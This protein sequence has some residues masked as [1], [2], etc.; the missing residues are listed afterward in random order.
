MDYPP[1]AFDA[2]IDELTSQGG[3]LLPEK[4]APQDIHYKG[5]GYEE[6]IQEKVTCGCGNSTR[7]VMIYK[8]DPKIKNPQSGTG[9]VTVCAV[10][11][12]VGAMPNF[13]DAV[14]DVSPEL[15]PMFYD[16]EDDDA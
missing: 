16:Q 14:Y 13:C 8:P 7:M 4:C 2:L 10:C 12:S 11:D 6:S 1:Q 3:A 5:P 9:Y 15:N